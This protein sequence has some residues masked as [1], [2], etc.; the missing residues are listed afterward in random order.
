[1]VSFLIGMGPFHLQHVYAADLQPRSLKLSDGTAAH[2]GTQYEVR[3]TTPGIS[4]IGSVKVQ[5]CSNTSLVDD[6]CTPPT[7]FDASSVSLVNQTSGSP[8]AI[9]GSSTANELLLTRPPAVEA[10]G[11]ILFTF[12][13]ITNPS[14]VGSYY[15]RIF[16]YPS[17]D[18]SGPFT[19]AN[20][21]AF[22]I[23]RALGVDVEVPPYIKFCIGESITN[24]D[25][26][27]ATEP[28]SDL[29][30][31]S[32]SITSAAQSQM[33]IATNA[34]SGYSMWVVGSTMTSGG[35]VINAMNGSPA[36]KGTSQFGLNLRA[37]NAPQIGQNP[38][39]PGS[40]G[41]TANYNQQ[42]IFRFTT[43][44]TLATAPVPDDNRKYTVSYIVNIPSGQPGGVY[45]TTLTYVCLANF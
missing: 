44:D 6:T 18:G 7:G 3:F 28:F 40:G 5:F 26:T 32:P 14:S 24:F 11:V 10:S 30:D 25:C 16:T 22:P 27:T 17:S 8:F 2:S 21:L 45:S 33:V 29:G 41:V 35:N 12:G 39:G 34:Q 43:G 15:S 36:V 31:L 42:N 37:N 23:A 19:Y 4:T 20:G 38:T 1:M 9:S 13:N